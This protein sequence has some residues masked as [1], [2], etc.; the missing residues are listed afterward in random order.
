MDIPR[1]IRT[2]SPREQISFAIA[3]LSKIGLLP[4]GFKMSQIAYDI[5]AGR[6]NP[7]WNGPNAVDRITEVTT[8]FLIGYACG[9]GQLGLAKIR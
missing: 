4:E 3:T 9:T 5:L 2:A 1:Q 7:I 6:L 8:D